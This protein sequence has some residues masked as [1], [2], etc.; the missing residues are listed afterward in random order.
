[1][2]ILRAGYKWRHIGLLLLRVGIGI[3]FI[4]HGWPKLAA[5]PERWEMIGQST[6]VLGIDFAPVFWGFMAGFAEVVGGFC[7]LLGFLFRPAC[8]L[9]V[10]TM[11]VATAKHAAAGDG[12]GGFSHALEAAILFFS[13]LFI[14]PGKYSLDNSI[15]PTDKK[16]SKAGYYK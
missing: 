12:F 1:M 9:L 14:G 11:L 4:L 13:L 15:F 10:I 8:M 3:M 16:R 7:I 5:G 2:A 6:Q